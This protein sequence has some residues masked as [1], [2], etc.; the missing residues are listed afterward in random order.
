MEEVVTQLG[1]NA[2]D[3]VIMG[4]D[5]SLT[6]GIDP[7]FFAKTAMTSLALQ[8][9]NIGANLMNIVASEARNL[10]DVIKNRQYFNELLRV[11]SELQ[12]PGLSGK[13]RKKLVAR[14]RAVSYKHLTLPTT[15]YV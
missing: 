5:K 8:G 9:G 15:P 2:S 11:E 7:T 13:R 10:K 4:E 12:T 14:K 3:I 1:Q 6:E